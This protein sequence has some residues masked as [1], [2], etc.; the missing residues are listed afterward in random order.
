MKKLLWTALVAAGSAAAASLTIRVL[1]IA[2]TKI[3]KE[4]P[5]EQPW[6]ARKLVGSPLKSTIEKNVEP[7]A[8]T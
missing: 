3:A 2:W 7:A 8:K 5:P 6:W 4:P 1:R